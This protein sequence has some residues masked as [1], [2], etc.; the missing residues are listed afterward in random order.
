MKDKILFLS[1]DRLGDY[2]I[3]S[4]VIYNISKY[5][6]YSDIICSN[7]NY[8][9]IS[10]QL[11]FNKVLL[12]D[13]SKKITN[14]FFYI[15]K[16]IFKRY[17]AVIS[18]DG[19]NISNILVIL[20]RADF[21]LIFIYKKLGYF[22]NL[23]NKLYCLLLNLFNIKY[24][25]L[26]SRSL[27]ENNEIDHFPTKFKLLKKYFNKVEDKTYHLEN[28]ELE[29][30]VY[31][32]KK[33]ILIHLDEK[34]ND[35]KLI[36]NDFTNSLISLSK[37]ID[38]KIILTSYNN[39]NLYYQNLDIKKIQFQNLE[40]INIY[41]DKMYILENIPLVEFNYLIKKSEINISCHGGFFVHASLLN[42]K[43]TIDIIND[44]E[45]KWISAWIT[46]TKNYSTISKSNVTIDKLLENLS[47]KI[48]EK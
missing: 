1:I 14:K 17:D 19:K 33:F 18:F 13:K 20:L 10:K 15:H 46:P 24:E 42:Q 44:S 8:K 4:N 41:D 48:N 16:F 25:I 23:K 3:R 27:I 11:F 26:N 7:I 32:E 28:F 22:S 6:K 29:K 36:N 21:K 31:F 12:F 5:Y 40:E 9:L 38:K 35:I 34:F 47:Y 2:L 37:K 39:R 30:S 45:D 43:K